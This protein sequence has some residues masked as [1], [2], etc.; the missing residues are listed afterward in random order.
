MTPSRN[1]YGLTLCPT[2]EL[3]SD[4]LD[5]E[6]DVA[7]ALADLRGAPVGAG[8]EALE[9]RALVDPAALDHEVLLDDP[10]ILLGVGDGAA[11]HL[12][13]GGRRAERRELQA[14]LCLDHVRAPD[15]VH[16]PPHLARRDPD[17]F[18][19]CSGFHL[20]FPYLSDVL[21]SVW[22]PWVRNTRVGANSPSLCP[23][24]DSETNT[25]TCLR[26]SWTAIV[27]PIISGMIV[28]RRDQVRTMRLSP[29]LF[30][31]SIL[32]NRCSSTNGPFFTERGI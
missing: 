1:P 29:R 4:V 11:Q 2:A 21:R 31:S 13:D 14:P 8:A 5:H 27:C 15:E 24:M 16:D 7:R 3:L 30:M 32:T 25:G 6:R 18:G 10:R 19:G 20:R 22:W 9:R 12:G 26:P 23:T 28:E 17:V